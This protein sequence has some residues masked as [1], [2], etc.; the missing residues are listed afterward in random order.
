M[1]GCGQCEIFAVL[2]RKIREN[3]EENYETAI[4]A[5]CCMRNGC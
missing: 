2:M 4:I 3:H 1:K 5:R